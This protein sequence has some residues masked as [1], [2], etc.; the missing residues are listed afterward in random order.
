MLLLLLLLVIFF[1]VRRKE[2]FKSSK[3]RIGDSNIH[4]KGIIAS[5]FMPKDTIIDV[6][7][8]GRKITPY[9]GKYINHCN[10]PNTCMKRMDDRY[11][12]VSTKDIFPGDEISCDYDEAKKIANFI[13]SSQKYYKC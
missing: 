5:S 9:F 1:Y 11:I 13:A 2:S 4:G 6:A 12:L 10:K 7:V 8:D 3:Y